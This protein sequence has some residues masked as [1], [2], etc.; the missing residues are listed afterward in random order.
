L[1]Q[2]LH[3]LALQSAVLSTARVEVAVAV[4]VEKEKEVEMVKDNE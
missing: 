4:A 3:V 2:L 1:P